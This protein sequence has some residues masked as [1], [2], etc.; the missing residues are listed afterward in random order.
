[1]TKLPERVG[2]D[3]DR[4]TAAVAL[5]EVL[6]GLEAAFDVFVT[7]IQ[8]R[9]LARIRAT[10]VS[11]PPQLED[12]VRRSATAVV[13]D[14][15]ARLRSQVGLPDELP[16]DLIGLAHLWAESAWEPANFAEAQLAG[17][18]VFWERFSVTTERILDDASLC[19]DVV[20]VARARL[21]GHAGRVNDLFRRAYERESA[22]RAGL[23]DGP[24]PAAV[25]RALEG[26]WDDAGEL[27]YDLACHH[28]AVVADAPLTLEGLARRAERDL[29]RVRA[30][31]GGVWGWLG[32][33]NRISDGDLDALVAW[34]HGREGHVAFGEPAGGIAGF[35]ESHRQAREAAATARAL[36]ERVVR[37]ADLLLPIA[38]LREPHLA[39]SFVERELGELASSDQRMRE[40]R[41]T[42]RAYLDHGQCVSAAAASLQRDRKTIQRRLHA[43]ERLLCRS[44]RDR[45]GE[46]LVALHTVEILR[47]GDHP[48][49]SDRV[50]Q[51]P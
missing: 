24:G 6:D 45:S 28:V 48:R 2:G 7:S 47:R 46:L 44:V 43:A 12:A 27:G 49:W 36:G 22:R 42:L 13:R 26:H 25:A 40:L 41:A 21:M 37:F 34:Q 17:E 30:P 51:W 8:D 29:L 33:R 4:D 1:M 20:K 31:G 39:R 32:G 14:A 5:A 23:Q 18:E 15:L 3:A 11:L 19:W 16:A 10:C 50:P 9:V 38:L 35:S